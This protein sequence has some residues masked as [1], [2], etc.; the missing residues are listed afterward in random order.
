MSAE[1]IARLRALF[2]A[3]LSAH[4]DLYHPIDVERVRTEEW[5]VKR[6][7][8]DQPDQEDE[9][10]AF[11]ALSKALQ[12][13]KSF[14]LHDR[15]DQ[16]FPKEIWELNGVE[17]YGKDKEGH[18]VQWEAVRNQVSIFVNF[19][20]IPSNGICFFKASFQGDGLFG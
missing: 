15:T 16:Y 4:P 2:E 20:K 18:L 8:L 1:A 12:W 5:Q 3:D 7:L 13:K 10:A 14:G 11:A 19:D 17:I 9:T 6:F